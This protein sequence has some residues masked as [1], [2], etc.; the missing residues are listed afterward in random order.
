MLYEI[1][2]KAYW[3]KTGEIFGFA[4]NNDV[5]VLNKTP[6]SIAKTFI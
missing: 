2:M 5:V 3:N 6:E 4:G 1:F